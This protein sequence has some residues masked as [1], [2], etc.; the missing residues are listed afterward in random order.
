MEKAICNVCNAVYL[1]LYHRYSPLPFLFA[2][3]PCANSQLRREEQ[4]VIST[5]LQVRPATSYSPSASK[6]PPDPQSDA[7]P[8]VS[9]S[10]AN[11]GAASAGSPSTSSGNVVDEEEDQAQAAA[12]VA[13]QSGGGGDGFVAVGVINGLHVQ[14]MPLG[15]E[16]SAAVLAASAWELY[17]VRGCGG[18][19]EDFVCADGVIIVCA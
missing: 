1:C 16:V 7:K 9:G 17:E 15:G 18:V 11:T 5:M 8:R 12:A 2:T 4:R 19:C 6:P 3:Y 14:R 13:G 10:T